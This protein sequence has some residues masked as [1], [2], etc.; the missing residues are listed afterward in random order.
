MKIELRNLSKTFMPG[1][2]YEQQALSNL[3]LTLEK[4]ELI[5]MIGNSGSGKT[6]AVRYMSAMQIDKTPF[7]FI[8]GNPIQN[9]RQTKKNIKQ[10]RKQIT[11]SFQFPTHQ[12]FKETIEG[13]IKLI[14]KNFKTKVD[15]DKAIKLFSEVGLNYK[16][17][18]NKVPLLM[19][20][21]EKRKIAIC[22]SILID[23]ELIIFDEPT[24]GLDPESEHKVIMLF[25]NLV[26]NGKKVLVVSHNL[27]LA[28]DNADRVVVLSD[29][30]LLGDSNWKILEDESIMNKAKLE[31]PLNAKV[32]SALNIETRRSK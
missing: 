10:L 29:G 28:Y 5:F 30:K 3:S 24:S 14:E 17:I 22:L 32:A 25:K 2:P 9:N 8:D 31:Q 26:K 19:S 16:D 20:E 4:S 18:L 6:T 11:L 13:E 7:L 27:E 12:L 23:T 1:T 21:G 15:R